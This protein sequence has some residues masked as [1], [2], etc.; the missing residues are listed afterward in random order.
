MSDYGHQ[1]G[2]PPAP[3]QP[4]A[5]PR[6]SGPPGSPPGHDH[7]MQASA[8][9][10]VSFHRWVYL[11]LRKSVDTLSG[12]WLL[13]AIAVFLVIVEGFF[14]VVG[15]FDTSGFTFTIF[16]SPMAYV[17]QPL[18]ATLA[19][20]LVTSEWGQRT[21]MVT[22][23]LEPRR[24]RVLAAKLVAALALTAAFIVVL[25]LIATI[26]SG[27]LAATSG[28]ELEWDLGVG[29]VIG[30]ML[31]LGIAVMIGFGLATLILNTPAAIG[32]FPIVAYAIPS[33]LGLVGLFWSDFAP[34]GRYL[35]LQTAT[36]P[37]LTWS[38]DTGS[39]WGHLAVALLVWM[40]IPLGLGTMRLLRAE[41][42]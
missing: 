34:V 42:K 17:L 25:L 1:P 23:A 10:S 14:L 12:F 4:P 18:L 15:L 7:Q 37:V 41:V 33:G 32:A 24:T 20:M 30:L 29:D 11:E 38:V 13:A 39:D 8:T 35:N 3:Q 22:F 9:P 28:G 16:T 19:I 36:N 27:I 2:P 21:A 40:V 5:Q 26:C 6:P 31:F